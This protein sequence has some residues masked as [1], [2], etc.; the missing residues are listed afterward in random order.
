[1]AYKVDNLHFHSKAEHKI[2]GLQYDHEFH[3]VHVMDNDHYGLP[4]PKDVNN[5]KMPYQ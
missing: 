2:N 5:E 4:V 3:I 1:M